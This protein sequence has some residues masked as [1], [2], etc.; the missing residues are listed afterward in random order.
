MYRGILWAQRIFMVTIIGFEH[1]SQMYFII[2]V[3]V[4]LFMGKYL[5]DD[6]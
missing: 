6:Y 4:I 5:D 3:I 1:Y 2:N